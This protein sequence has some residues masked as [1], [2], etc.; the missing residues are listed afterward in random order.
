VFGPSVEDP[1]RLD[2]YVV[3]TGSDSVLRYHGTTGTFLGEFLTSGSGDLQGPVTMTFRPNGDLL[4]ADFYSSDLAVKRF[5]GP[6][7]PTPGEFIDTF[8]PAGRGGLRAPSGLIFGPDGNADG[9]LDLYVAEVAANGF[10][11]A[12]VKRYDGVTGDFIDTFVAERSGGLEGAVLLTFT[13]T[14]PVTLA[15]TGATESGS[16][17]LSFVVLDEKSSGPVWTGTAVDAV[18]ISSLLSSPV[19]VGP[20]LSGPEG[21]YPVPTSAGRGVVEQPPLG[22]LAAETDYQARIARRA[23]VVDQAITAIVTH[24][25]TSS[26]GFLPELDCDIELLVDL[27]LASQLA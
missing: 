15:Y 6:S 9:Q 1:H 25:G 26:F 27:A 4:V 12:S 11:K 21:A 5:Q 24:P 20:N 23:E 2:L 22:D 8:V 14:D 17:D 19:L 7:G 16:A 3:S 13:D 18:T 10:I